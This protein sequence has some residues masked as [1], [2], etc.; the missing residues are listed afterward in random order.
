MSNKKYIEDLLEIMRALRDTRT[1]CPWDK[2]QSFETIAPY[3]IEE[4]YEVAEAIS[5][6]DMQDLCDELGDLLLQVVYHAQIANETNHFNFDDVVTAICKKMVRRHPHVFGTQQQTE[7]GKQDWESIKKQERVD[8]GG[9]LQ[10]TSALAN[11]ALGLPALIRARK[12]QKKAAKVNFDWPNV[13]GVLEKIKEE[14]SELNEAIQA[15]QDKQR[16]QDEVGDVLFSVIN[17]C[18]HMNVDADVALQQ[19]NSKFEGRF[20]TMERLVEQQDKKITDL[21][22][23]ELDQYWEQAKILLSDSG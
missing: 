5:R 9:S 22:E 6:N 15:H 18:R 7:Q 17:L 19:S 12:L 4:A 1:G 13:Q 23:Q 14:V 8:K 11:V 10:D 21:T 16:I 20:R 2:Q 3:T